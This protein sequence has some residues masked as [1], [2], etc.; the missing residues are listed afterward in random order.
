MLCI[1]LAVMQINLFLAVLKNKFAKAQELYSKV[2]QTF[3][4][5]TATFAQKG[6]FMHTHW[7]YRLSHQC[8]THAAYPLLLGK[9]CM[10]GRANVVL[11]L[12]NADISFFRPVLRR[13]SPAARLLC[14]GG[15]FRSGYRRIQRIAGRETK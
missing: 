12:L 4:S 10:R 15:K 8:K 11:S 9:V 3:P 2:K 1:A 6:V 13:T 5:C 14:S 7:L